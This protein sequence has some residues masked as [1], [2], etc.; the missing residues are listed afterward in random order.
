[1]Q[2]PD[3]QI[4]PLDV[5]VENVGKLITGSKRRYTWRFQSPQTTHVLALT[6]SFMSSKFKLVLDNSEL[7]RGDVP[8][9][10]PFEH[11][12]VRN[13]LQFLIEQ[14][15]TNMK[16][17]IN[18]QLFEPG[19]LIDIAAA[20]LGPP[21]KSRSV[22]KLVPKESQLDRPIERRPTDYLIGDPHP[23]PHFAT[24]PPM[25]HPLP[26]AQH[27]RQE[28]LERLRFQKGLLV[29]SGRSAP[30]TPSGPSASRLMWP[31]LD[32]YEEQP[33]KFFPMNFNHDTKSVASII[34][35]LYCS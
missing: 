20:R 2:R 6:I 28:D 24:R 19:C 34:T 22:A 15:K 29:G 32:Q 30:S 16:L 27:S 10:A 11:R 26:P 7:E 18:G 8:Y 9:F 35:K 5:R 1:M 31:T 13:E 3:Y 14:Q 17:Y 23:G 4:R 25:P 12:A 21:Q 33:D